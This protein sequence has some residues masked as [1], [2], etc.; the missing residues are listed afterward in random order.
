MI[1]LEK[2]I[3]EKLS[4]QIDNIIIEGLKMKGFEF[5]NENDLHDFIKQKCSCEDDLAKQQRVYFVNDIPFLL[6]NYEIV[7]EPITKENN[8]IKISANYGTYKYL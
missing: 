3:T 7:I 8:G 6:H 1:R 5:E 2:Q 4:N